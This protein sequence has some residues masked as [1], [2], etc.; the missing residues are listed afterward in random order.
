VGGNMFVYFSLEQVR[1]Q[2]FRGPDVFAV[3]DVPR[4]ERKSWVIWEEGKGPDV[5]IELLSESTNSRDKTEKKKIYQSRMRVPEYF[6][7]DPFNPEDFQ[8]F[9]LQ[10]SIYQP[11]EPDE[12]GHFISQ[13]LDLALV[14][15]SGS[16]REIETIWLRW[17]T[18]SGELLPTT[19]EIAEQERQRA[20]QERQRADQT[21]IQLEQAQQQLEEMKQRL[22][23]M[24]L[25]SP[26]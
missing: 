10:G 21:Q 18:L 16:Y 19:E 5:V 22:R 24:G 11:I 20:E 6:W 1:N 4:K 7:Y 9:R 8:G 12:Q 2:D 17:A 26:E 3:L 15:W 25:D 13:E 23:E 14:K